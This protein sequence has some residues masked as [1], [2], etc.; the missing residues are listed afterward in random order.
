MMLRTTLILFLLSL[1]GFEAGRS[2]AQEP[3]AAS[4]VDFADGVLP[5]LSKNCVACHNSKKAEGGL[6]LESHTALMQGGDSGQAVTAGDVET[7]T[8]LARITD[9]DDPMPPEGNSVGAVR[10]TESEVEAIRQWILSGAAAP[11]KTGAN[12]MQWQPLPDSVHPIYAL[13]ASPDGNY[14]AFGRG[15]QAFVVRQGTAGTGTQAFELSDALVNQVI[16]GSSEAASPAKTAAHLDIVQSIAF[17][18]DSQTIATGGFRDVKLWRRRTQPMETTQAAIN[19]PNAPTVSAISSDG[20][21]IA[22][23]SEGQLEIVDLRAGKSQ[24]FLK[25]HAHP[26]SSLTW[27]PGTGT[28][29]SADTGGGMVLTDV[30]DSSASP[31][32]LQVLGQPASPEASPASGVQTTPSESTSP[33]AGPWEVRQIV[34]LGGH[35]L[36]AIDGASQVLEMTLHRETQSMTVRVVD[37]FSNATALASI[38]QAAPEGAASATS[39]IAIGSGD[40]ACRIVNA[41]SWQIVK[42][43]ATSEP[44]ASIALSPNGAHVVTSSGQSPA[45]VWRVEDGAMVTSLDRDYH[46]SQLVSSSTRNAARQQGLMER[47]K[48]RL[49]EAK[50]A[51][52]AE[53][54]ARAKI[55]ETR[56]KASEDVAAKETAV[57]AATE[58]VGQAEQAVAA[59][60]AAVAE[61]MK[62]VETRKAELEAKRKA[63]EEAKTQKE[64]AA[65][66]LASREQALATAQDATS[67]AMQR[68]PEAE[69]VIAQETQ[70]LDELQQSHQRLVAEPISPKNVKCIVVSKDGSRVVVS[71]EKGQQ[72]LFSVVDGHPEAIFSSDGPASGLR[73]TD[74]GRLVVLSHSGTAYQ[75]DLSLPWELHRSIGNF[76]ESPMSDRITALDFSPDS[77]RLAVGSGPPS[78]FG[79]IKILD[80]DSG[81]VVVDLGEVHSDSVLALKFSPTGRVLASGAADK[82]CRLFDAQTGALLGTLEGHTHHVLSLAWKDDAVTLATGSADA[83]VKFWN[84]ESGTQLRTVGDFKKE[85][86]SLAFVAQSDQ[87]VATD[88]AG[89]AR[90]ISAGDGK[91]LRAYAGADSGIYALSVSPDG[92][93]LFA[94]G[95][96]G[97]NWAWQIE[98]GKQLR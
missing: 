81:Q 48:A 88:A 68:I 26:I 86:T 21:R 70:K 60:E 75:W 53:E 97:N 24:R 39:L 27:L 98:D 84:V 89:N 25:A 64:K 30:D 16:Q 32:A 74:D 3:N 12:R 5:L 82:Q 63:V 36:A 55:Q 2:M 76:E 59:A 96:S 52:E 23:A 58:A 31:I 87:L 17:S 46:F 37:G 91:Q 61:A 20:L 83:S 13:S 19:L 62:L 18:P 50:K 90:L 41:D 92:K 9:D 65:T 93:T 42:E 38:I 67:R 77:G 1:I 10:L 54:A 4:V 8:L 56:D 29:L 22:A 95:H 7:G 66:E 57:G 40:G 28:L 73:A 14:L 78:R 51:A 72:H 47:L 94:G 80:V 85:V 35:R 69:Q 71:D 44:V 79:E 6:N 34:S 43:I 49:E 11:A 33:N 15:S 45:K